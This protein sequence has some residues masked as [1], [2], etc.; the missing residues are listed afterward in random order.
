MGLYLFVEEQFGQGEE[1]EVSLKKYPGS[2][3]F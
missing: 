2:T 3:L 1:D